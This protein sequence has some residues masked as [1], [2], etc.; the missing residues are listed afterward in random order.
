MIPRAPWRS[1]PWHHDS[2]MQID[3]PAAKSLLFWLV[4][5]I[6]GAAIY[7]FSQYMQTAS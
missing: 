4:L 2:V 3:S 7:F 6:V 1:G 5:V